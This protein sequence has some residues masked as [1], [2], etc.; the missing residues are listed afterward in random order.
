MKELKKYDQMSILYGLSPSISAEYFIAEGGYG[1]VY[2][3]FYTKPAILKV[4]NT[5]LFNGQKGLVSRMNVL[6]LNPSAHTVNIYSIREKSDRIWIVMEKCSYNLEKYQA[7]NQIPDL[8]EIFKFIDQILRAVM[9]YHSLGIM[10]GRIAFDKIYVLEEDNLKMIKVA[11]SQ[12]SDYM[13]NFATSDS[14]DKY[15]SDAMYYD[16][17]QLAQVIVKLLWKR[18]LDISKSTFD[19]HSFEPLTPAQG[20]A[21]KELV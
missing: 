17:K 18:E 21:I 14:S 4:W 6:H 10:V 11:L 12:C 13:E 9:H 3:G 15:Q 5:Q 20:S 1:R 19:L 7:M 8:P 2:A 16:L